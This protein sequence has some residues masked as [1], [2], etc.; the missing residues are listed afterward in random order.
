MIRPVFSLL[1][2]LSVLSVLPVYAQSLKQRLARRLDAPPFNRQLW[3]VAVIDESGR[4]LYGRNEGRLFIPASNTKLV[5]GAVA[6]ALLPPDWTVT[7]SL[8]GGPIVGGVLLGDLVLYGRG[9]PTMDRR[10][11]AA[12]TTLTGECDTDPFARLRH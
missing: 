3:G 11:Y 12:D 4:L 10:C 5:V 2:V 8:Y 7:T 9:D 1:C 6:A